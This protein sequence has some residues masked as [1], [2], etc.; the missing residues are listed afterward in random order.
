MNWSHLRRIVGASLTI[1]CFAGSHALLAQPAT[2]SPTPVPTPAAAQKIEP[3]NE[4]VV[5][6]ATKMAQD[7]LDIPADITVV[8]GEELRRMGTTTLAEALTNVVGLDT[9]DGS[10][11]GPRIPNIGLFGIK[12]FDALMVMVDGV[13]VGGPFNPN[14][15]QVPVENIDRIEISRGPQG[16]LYGV[17][18]FAGMIQVFTKGGRGTG[19]VW[20]S[21]RLGGFGAF[22]QVFGQVNVGTQVNK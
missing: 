4:E 16:T 13:P 1:A 8:S 21:A 7:P 9:M 15:S 11:N 3:V 22:D 18:A 17:S 19:D 5:V 14:L 10:D 6:S 12:E 20:G 2:P